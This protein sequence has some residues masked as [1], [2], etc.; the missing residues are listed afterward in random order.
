MKY[1]PDWK[2][3]GLKCYFCNDNR[4]VKY[5]VIIT[6]NGNE[7]EVYSCNKCVFLHAVK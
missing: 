4:S 7:K 1:V 2:N 5:K 3:K 6:E